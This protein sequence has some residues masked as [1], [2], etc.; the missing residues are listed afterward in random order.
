[1]R[2]DQEI[3]N[4]ILEFDIS[5]DYHPDFHDPVDAYYAAIDRVIAFLNGEIN[6]WRDKP[7]K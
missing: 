4:R 6:S 5:D 2:V 3:I 7:S 1:M